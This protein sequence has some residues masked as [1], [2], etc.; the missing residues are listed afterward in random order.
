MR[1]VYIKETVQTEPGPEQYYIEG[2]R[3]DAGKVLV[4]R[5]ICCTWSDRAQNEEAAYYVTDAG[6]KIYLGDEAGKMSPAHPGWQGCVAIGEGDKV[7]A[8][9]PDAATSDVVSLFVCG[10]LWD[11]E[12]WRDV[13]AA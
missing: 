5:S 6:R 9:N 7:G 1:E 3:V 8:Y 12:D 10:E 2:E 13:K 11:L 4:I